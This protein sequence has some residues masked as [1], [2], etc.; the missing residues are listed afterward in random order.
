[1]LAKANKAKNEVGDRRLFMQRQLEAQQAPL[2]PSYGA[3]MPA[4]PRMSPQSHATPATFGRGGHNS[5]PAPGPK[6]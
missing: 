6:G 3:Q 1:M 4:V 2:I 5:V